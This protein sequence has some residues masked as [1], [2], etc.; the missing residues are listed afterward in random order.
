MERAIRDP[1]YQKAIHGAVFRRAL[2]S[3]DFDILYELDQTYQADKRTIKT[4]EQIWKNIFNKPVSYAIGVE[5]SCY[6]N[7]L[8]ELP[9]FRVFWCS[10][11]RTKE[12]NIREQVEFLRK[13]HSKA[14]LRNWAN[15]QDGRYWNAQKVQR[16]QAAIDDL[17]D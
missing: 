17:P 3:G 12:D 1:K 9:E 15:P 4:N 11:W 7:I 6:S 16:I 5:N 13:Y 14:D 10:Y 2:N 8:N